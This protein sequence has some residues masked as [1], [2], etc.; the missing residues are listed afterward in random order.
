MTIV[1]YLRGLKFEEL[2]LGISQANVATPTAPLSQYQPASDLSPVQSNVNP[3][4]NPLN[5]S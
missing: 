5:S 2:K 4:S 3:F 1:R